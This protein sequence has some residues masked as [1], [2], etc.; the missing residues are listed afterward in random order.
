MNLCFA[1]VLR[2]EVCSCAAIGSEDSG[3]EDGFGRQMNE[4]ICDSSR[5]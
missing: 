3:D 2:K 4:N 1:F 5:V